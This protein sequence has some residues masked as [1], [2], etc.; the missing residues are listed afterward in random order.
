MLELSGISVSLGGRAILDGVGFTVTAGECVG[1]IGANGAGKSTL[2]KV[3]SGQLRPDR[4]SARLDGRE[5]SEIGAAGLSRRRAVVAQSVDLSF[6]FTAAEI[7]RFGAEAGG[8]SGR[9]RGEIAESALAQVD[10]AGHAR[11]LVP[12]LSG[13]EAQ[14]VHLARGIAQIEAA[15]DTAQAGQVAGGYFL[16]LDEPTASL[17]LRHQVETLTLARRLAG[18]GIGI[19]AVLHDLNLAAM[20]SDRIVALKDGRVVAA[21]PVGSVVDDAM[22]EVVYGIALPVGRTPP[23]LPFFLPQMA[24]T[25]NG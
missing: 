6:P 17:D 1:V 24:V 22:V 12:S 20:A 3:L 18:R 10:M 25:G 13:G 19:V 9:R 2:M 16:L 23:T 4:G 8:A 15:M 14:R 21:G 5:L 11:Q 7:V